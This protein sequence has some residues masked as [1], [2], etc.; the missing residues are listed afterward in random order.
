MALQT[1]QK[2]V[3]LLL[4]LVAIIVFV[5]VALITGV[6]EYREVCT[7]YSKNMHARINIARTLMKDTLFR[8]D[9]V[10][11]SILKEHPDNIEALFE[12]LSRSNY[13]ES[14]GDIYILDPNGRVLY[15]SEP[16]SEYK[17]L[18]FSSMV[19]SESSQWRKVQ[20]HYQSLLSKRSVV[21]IQYPLNNQFVLVVERSLNTFIPVM[22]VFEEGKLYNDE[23]FFVLSTNGRALYHPDRQLMDTR[24]NVGFELKERSSPNAL[25]L[26]DFT[27]NNRNYIALSAQFTEPAD[28]M[29]YYAIPQSV[30]QAAIQKALAFQLCL[31]LLGFLLLFTTLRLIFDK[32]FS[33]PVNTLVAALDHSKKN[34]GLYLTPEMSGGIKEIQSIIDAIHSRDEEVSRT[35]ER[36]QSVLDSLDAMV[37]VADMETYEVLFMNRYGRK[38]WG[39]AIGKKCYETLQEGKSTPC[40]FCTNHLLL[41]ENGE[42]NEVHTWEFQNTRTNQW[43]ECRDSAI[44]WTDGKLVRMEIATDISERKEA[45]NAL[46]AE[47]ER[48]SVTLRS[49]G[50]GVITTDIQGRIIFLNKIAEELSGW[51][52]E[53]AQGKP[54]TEVFNIINEKTGQKCVSPVQ[55]VIELGRIIG[56]ANHTALIAKDGS[57]R[58]IADSGAP[59]RDR[60]SKIIGV[61][62]VFRDVTHEKKMEEELL[63][64]RKLESVGV[65][66]GGIAHDFNNILSGILGNIELA[67]Y[68]IP[69][70]ETRTKTLLE[71]AEKATKR[72][73]KLTE[74]LLTFSKGGE[75][76]KALTSLPQLIKES[77]G[78]VLHGSPVAC[79]YNF[80]DNLWKVDI[81]SGQINQVIQNIIINAKHALPEGGTISISCTNISDAAIEALLSVDHGDYVRLAISDK[82]IGIP[83]EIITKVFDPYFSTKQEGSGLGLAICHSIINKHN[84][85]IT[86]H[87]EPGK[88]TTFTL[89]LPAVRS[90]VEENDLLQR[91]KNPTALRAARVM[92]MDDEE[93]IRNVAVSQLTLLGHEAIP[94]MDGDQ[95]INKYLEMEDSKK[96]ID[97]VI[98]DLTIPGGKGGLETAG[99]LLQI[100]PSLKLVV[101]SG[102]SNDPVLANYQQYGFSGMVTKPFDL[103]QLNSAINTS[104]R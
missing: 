84:G 78:F 10:V 4:S 44:R 71:N 75:P 68:H 79:E 74:Q 54:S 83:Q 69:E 22:A 82:G 77:A 81:D 5:I 36:F 23:L 6:F 13:F 103:K 39:N 14:A 72:A 3:N 63:K 67:G 25:G 27:Y 101:A 24:H 19:S 73:A 76:V 45:V 42:P 31:L 43:F 99:K 28:W 52:N 96:P 85:H 56:L 34:N 38:K 21:T 20:H 94:V 50:D 7:E 33:S 93:M 57:T 53:E 89:F 92:I 51:S 47:R 80:D 32:F 29:I 100:N 102:Y 11:N 64:I 15:I 1:L 90:G 26:F 37:Y 60:Q 48:L 49:I 70:E 61:V 88:G 18:N 17:G 30:M 8:T 40:D 35:L 59:I 9:V 46:D 55:R 91:S 95:A 87:S 98:L 16:Y 2:R 104:L 65:L 58:S 97:I 12:H 41:D 62:L 66:A 86:V